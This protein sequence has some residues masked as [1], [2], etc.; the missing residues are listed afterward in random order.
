[1]LCGMAAG[2]LHAGWAAERHLRGRIVRFTWYGAP[3]LREGQRW[4]VS[5]RV[6]PPWGYRNPAGFDYERWLFGQR[7]HGTGYIRR[8]SLV[9]AGAHGGRAGFADWLEQRGTP[10]R[11]MILVLSHG[12]DSG[13]TARQWEMLRASGA[14]HLVVISGLHVGMVA[15]LLLVAARFLAGLA[16]GRRLSS[17]GIYLLVLFAVLLWDPLVVH[18]QGF[19]LSFAAAGVLVGHFARTYPRRGWLW[20]L[21]CTQMVLLLVLSPSINSLSV[22]SSN[23]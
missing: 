7:L 11:A 20:Q 17:A 22:G 6:R 9:A 2:L 19:W 5:A 23:S 16:P 4:Q 18:Q 13:I 3:Q 12:D 1:M 15:G 14:V 8:G 21:V 10:H